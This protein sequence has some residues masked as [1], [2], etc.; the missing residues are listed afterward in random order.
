MNLS[1]LSRAGLRAGTCALALALTLPLAAKE[2]ATAQPQPEPA[3]QPEQDDLESASDTTTDGGEIVVRS[4]RLRGQLFVDQ[5]PLL[6]LDETAIASEGVTS[7]TDLIAQ[8]SARTGSARGRGG[9]GQPV[10]L[11]NGI[12]IGSFREFANYPPEALARVEVFPEEVAQRFGFPPDRRVIN[13]ILKDN[14]SNRQVDLEYE[15]PSRGAMPVTNS[16]SAS[17]RS[18]M[19]AGS[20]PISRCRTRPC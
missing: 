7:I 2:T 18:P 19:A 11:V 8:I 16:S 17:S 12:R 14:Y 15:M 4:G 5:A 20:T 10:I 1:P 6:E 3:A 13:L 9:G